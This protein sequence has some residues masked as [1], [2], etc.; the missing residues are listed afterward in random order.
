M[1]TLR[2]GDASFNPDD[3]TD[4]GPINVG[5]RVVIRSLIGSADNTF[6]KIFNETFNRSLELIAYFTVAGAFA[7]DMNSIARVFLL[8]T[9]DANG[10]ARVFAA[11]PGTSYATTFIVERA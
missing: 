9:Y 6:R 1:F 11:S 8:V 4:T 5:G 3:I 2:G 10:D 7:S